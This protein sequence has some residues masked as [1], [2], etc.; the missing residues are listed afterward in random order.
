MSSIKIA[1]LCLYYLLVCIVASNLA[2]RDYDIPWKFPVDATMHAIRI[3]GYFGC[4][5]GA[6][7]RQRTALLVSAATVSFAAM[8]N[9]GVAVYRIQDYSKL[10]DEDLKSRLENP[11]IP[12]KKFKETLQVINVITVISLITCHALLLWA[13]V[14]YAKC[15]KSKWR[16]YR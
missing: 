6:K 16:T 15:I 4:I 3:L 1:M 2:N 7:L 13:C 8:V 10:S 9:A 11:N 14:S 5:L 12:A